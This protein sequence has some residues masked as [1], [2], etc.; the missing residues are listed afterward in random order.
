MSVS[1][2]SRHTNAVNAQLGPLEEVLMS[3]HELS[4]GTVIK[5]EN[6]DRY[7]ETRLVAKRFLPREHFGTAEQLFGLKALVDI[8][9]G[10]YISPGQ[11]SDGGESKEPEIR[12]GLRAVEVPVVASPSLAGLI[13]PGSQVD[14]LVTVE[15]EGGAGMTYL[16]YENLPVIAVSRSA[17]SGADTEGMKAEEGLGKMLVTV[18]VSA[19][20]AVYLVAAENFAKQIRVLPRSSGDNRRI[21]RLGVRKSDL[22][23]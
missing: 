19:G 21:G 8:P 7:L 20:V 12:T 18:R 2:V 23:P 11:L 15:A 10:T 9:A 6:A 14:F 13:V 22:K 17:D 5:P 4:E 16:A 1:L 3:K